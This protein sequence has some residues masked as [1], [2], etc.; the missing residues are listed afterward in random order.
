MTYF[1]IINFIAVCVYS[2][3]YYTQGQKWQDGCD[4]DCTCVNGQ[5]G[6]FECTERWVMS[7]SYAQIKKKIFVQD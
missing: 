1:I 7:K 6:V 3:K 2:G 4:Y 5:M